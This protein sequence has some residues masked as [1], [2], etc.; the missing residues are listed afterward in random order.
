MRASAAFE[1]FNATYPQFPR[2]A[3]AVTGEKTTN[4]QSIRLAVDRSDNL[5]RV[6]RCKKVVS[7]LTL[8]EVDNIKKQ[9]AE[10]PPTPLTEDYISDLIERIKQRILANGILIYGVDLSKTTRGENLTLE[11]LEGIIVV[12]ATSTE[13]DIVDC[14]LGATIKGFLQIF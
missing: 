11:Y 2:W 12:D 13:Q 7:A 1:S 8:Q 10:S 3:I 4:F 9:F 14:I 5:T 6:R